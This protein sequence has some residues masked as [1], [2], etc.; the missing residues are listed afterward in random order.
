[1]WQN[2]FKRQNENWRWNGIVTFCIYVH[3]HVN[4]FQPFKGHKITYIWASATQ[5][6]LHMVVN[7][8]NIFLVT[9]LFLIVLPRYFTNFFKP[10]QFNLKKLL[11]LFFI[12]ATI[13]SLGFYFGNA[14]FFGFSTNLEDYFSFLFDIIWMNLFFTSFPFCIVFLFLFTHFT[15]KDSSESVK[16]EVVNNFDSET[17]KIELPETEKGTPQ[18]KTPLEPQLLVFDDASSKKSLRITLDKL[19]YITSSQNYVEV[20]YQSGSADVKRIV[21]RNSLKA[22]EAEMIEG[23]QL[24]LLRCH[25]AFIVNLEKVVD[26]RGTSHGAQFILDKIDLPIPVSRQKYGEVKLM[27]NH[28]SIIS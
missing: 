23:A 18:Y 9:S 10:E 4:A 24:P 26:L 11:L 5:Y 27:F 22:I 15:G 12:D 8:V 20:F 13:I 3:I 25:K 6:W 2:I 28:F 7:F 1:M 17:V 14:H 21:L 19:F 16:N